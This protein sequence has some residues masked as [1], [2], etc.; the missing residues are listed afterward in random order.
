[1]WCYFKYEKESKACLHMGVG[2]CKIF[3]SQREIHSQKADFKNKCF[4]SMSPYGCGVCKI[5]LCQ[6]A[7]ESQTVDF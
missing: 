1:M 4:K 2:V 6:R 7:V 3:L 5:Y